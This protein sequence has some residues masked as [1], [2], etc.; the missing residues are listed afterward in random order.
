MTSIGKIPKHWQIKKL[1]DIF[2]VYG[3]TTPS[4]S[5]VE[6]WNGVIPWVTPT[7]ITKIKNNIFLDKTEKRITEKAIKACSLNILD[8]GT[9]L[10]T[11]RATIGE[12][13][14]NKIPVTINQGM[15]ALIPKKREE[16]YTMFY[17][18]YLQTLKPYL[19]QLGSGSTFREIS[20]SSLKNI[21][22]PVLSF[23]EQEQISTIFF[24]I[25]RRLELLKGKKEK[26]V[27]I[28]KGLMNDLFSGE[29]RVKLEI[30]S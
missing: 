27:R 17:A 12:V 11:S 16:I 20:K 26:L 15:T 4:T 9:L 24:I 10:L 8:K 18:Y 21:I 29:K 25:D 13:T 6:F 1:S 22:I 28:K 7:D 14:I 5:N 23:K 2:N 19:I 30:L 3:G